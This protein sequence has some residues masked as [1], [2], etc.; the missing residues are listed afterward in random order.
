[1]PHPC[2]RFL[3]GEA[4]RVRL[5]LALGWR[6]F[7]PGQPSRRFVGFVNALPPATTSTQRNPLLS[8]RLRGSSLFRYDERRFV[9][10]LLFHEAPRST[11]CWPAGQLLPQVARWLSRWRTLQNSKIEFIK[12]FSFR[13]AA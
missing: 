6:G 3:Q 10:V 12:I 9:S 2:I 7:R 5:F 8:L 4:A 13:Y 1:M 11:R